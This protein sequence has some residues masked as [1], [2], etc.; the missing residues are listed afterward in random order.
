VAHFRNEAADAR[1]IETFERLRWRLWHGQVRRALDLI[2]ETI[3]IVDS[4]ADN[5]SP[6][7]AAARILGPRLSAVIAPAFMRMPRVRAHRS[8]AGW[9]IASIC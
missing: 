3:A 9:L 5:I 8:L 6:I 1:L 7:T 2:G 4:P